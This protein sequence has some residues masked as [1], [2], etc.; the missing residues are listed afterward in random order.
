MKICIHARWDAT[1]LDIE[2]REDDRIWKEPKTIC[3]LET[4]VMD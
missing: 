1:T 3:Q 2:P 4:N